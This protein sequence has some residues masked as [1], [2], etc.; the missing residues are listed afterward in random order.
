MWQSVERCRLDDIVAVCGSSG[1]SS[2]RSLTVGDV[3]LLALELEVLLVVVMDVKTEPGRVNVA[4]APDEKSTEDR[5]RQ[6]I[7]DAVEDGLRIRRDVVATLAKTPS[8]RVK[9]PQKRGQGTTL[10]ES[11][12]DVLAHRV[13]VLAS[14][15]NKLVD[16][17]EQRGA[18]EGEIAP[19]VAGSDESAGKTSDDHDLVDE[20]SEE[21]GRPGHAGGEKQVGEQKRSG[22][23]PVDVANCRRLVFR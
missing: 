2:S 4:V 13:G 5:L 16:D 23:D 1:G 11:S 15:P 12:A 20:D 8:N 6:H 22:D 17:V 21:N 19:L 18:A 7:K 10:Q 3:L 14:F 9:R